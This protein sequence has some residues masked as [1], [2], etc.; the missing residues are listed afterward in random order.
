M[1]ANDKNRSYCDNDHILNKSEYS[2]IPTEE[3]GVILNKVFLVKRNVF[4][5]NYI[6]TG[7]TADSMEEWV[8]MKISLQIKMLEEQQENV[9]KNQEFNII[10][11]V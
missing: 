10:F 1:K 5:V 8:D 9:K 6:D 7:F 3:N 11:S 4:K 2:I